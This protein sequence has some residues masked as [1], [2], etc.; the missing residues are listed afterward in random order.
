MSV[1]SKIPVEIDQLR[2]SPAKLPFQ[3]CC[4]FLKDVAKSKHLK[5]VLSATLNC[6]GSVS[7]CFEYRKNG[8]TQ[9]RK[10][11]NLFLEEADTLENN[12]HLLQYSLC[13]QANSCHIK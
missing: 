3:N 9:I 6:D 13:L 2:A 1:E 12:T 4:I 7:P 10:E 5:T 8:A 11:L